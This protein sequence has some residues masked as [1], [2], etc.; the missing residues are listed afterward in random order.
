[1]PPPAV[2]LGPGPGGVLP[3][4]EGI[5]P[6][7]YLETVSF[8]PQLWGGNP[9]SELMR[10][11]AEQPP[12]EQKQP[13]QAEADRE[14]SGR[15]QHGRVEPNG[16]VRERLM[17]VL[18]A[19]SRDR[20]Q[21]I[22]AALGENEAP[23]HP[24]LAGVVSFLM[25]E[26]GLPPER[27]ASVLISAPGLLLRPVPEM[28]AVTSMVKA[29]I[30]EKDG[31]ASRLVAAQPGVLLLEAE[32]DLN[33]RL[34]IL[35]KNADLAPAKAAKVLTD[36]PRILAPDTAPATLAAVVE[37]LR[38][39]VLLTFKDTSRVLAAFPQLL[40][41]SVPDDL[42]P[43]VEWLKEIGVAPAK[44][45][46]VVRQHPKVFAYSLDNNLRP[47]VSY[48]WNEVGMDGEQLGRIVAAFPQVL[49]LSVP[50]KIRPLMTYL[51][52]SVGVPQDKLPR[53]LTAFPQLL[54]LSLENNIVPHVHYLVEEVG[55]PRERLGKVLA[56]FPHLLAYNLED[57]LRPTVEYFSQHL[58][59]PAERIGKLVATHPQI[60]G[61]SVEDK[62]IPTVDY[63]VGELGVP[64][65]QV[66]L[67][68]ERC[69]KILGCSIDKNL[70]PTVEF[71][72]KEVRIPLAE[73]GQIAVK[74][75]SLLGLSIDNNLRPK[76]NYLTTELQIELDTI[77]QQMVT[78]PQ[79]L[80]YSLEKRIKPR[81]RLLTGKGLKLGLHS[82]LAPTDVTFYQ[83]Y[84]GEAYGEGLARMSANQ[85]SLLPSG[86]SSS[87]K[88]YWHANAKRASARGAG[89]QSR[90]L[91]NADAAKG[92]EAE[93]GEGARGRA[94]GQARRLRPAAGRV[95]SVR[96]SGTTTRKRVA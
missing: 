58:N 10:S 92:G 39:D 95:G 36:C 54:G 22:V 93:R 18:P 68:V 96:E 28:R 66:A 9:I 40:A 90:S 64:K 94:A 21:R 51:L 77:S 60:L 35:L 83:R 43:T 65:T 7:M 50:L 53:M 44:V 32:G 3:S 38:D 56:S 2:L 20:A 81:H 17:A 80:A 46:K 70:R 89:K 25:Q 12:V 45:P 88:Y 26:L 85:A 31:Y 69:P 79:L 23:N 71:L 87:G 57:N 67:V 13:E 29:R 91:G 76:L 74:Y 41:M 42:A 75:P 30:Q 33:L 59:I 78:C 62:L 19:L 84:G 47:T 82:M 24:H 86:S 27:A 8:A 11:P 37:F 1:M 72:R 16:D 73:V 48:L 4:I 55:I 63:L 61:Y 15:G 49:G 52:D 5:S 14:A 6:S 34:D